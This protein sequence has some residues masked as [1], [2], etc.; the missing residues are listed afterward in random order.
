MTVETDLYS[1]L[2]SLVSNRVYPDLA[3]QGAARPFITYQQVGGR[4]IAFLETAVVGRRNSRLQ[5]NVWAATRLAA[6][7]LA[8]SVEDTLVASATLRAIPL[9][10]FVTIFEPDTG[11]YGTRQDFSVWS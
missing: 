5:V 4:A 10:A 6:N 3:P 11:L 8:R 9:H 7:N 1:A 2:G